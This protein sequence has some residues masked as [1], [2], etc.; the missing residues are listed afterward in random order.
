[1]VCVRVENEAE[2]NCQIEKYLWGYCKDWLVLD[3]KE[4]TRDLRLEQ[5]DEYGA[6]Y[7]P[8]NKEKEV[9][10]GVRWL[11]PFLIPSRT[12][13]G[14]WAQK[15][16][17]GPHFLITGNRL[18]SASETFPE[19]QQQVQTAANQGREGMQRQGRNKRNNSVALGQS[20]GSP[21]GIRIIIYLSCFA[22]T[23]TPARWEKLTVCCPQAGRPQNGWNQK[24]DDATSPLPH[25]QSSEECPRADHALFEQLL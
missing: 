14:S 18:P 12:L 11:I 3:E 24:V 19:F 10:C 20:P 21:Q 25:H 4:E 1:M 17:C 2:R 9:V 15:P 7:W 5:T 8:G 22:D 16:F 23:E 13:W 6:C